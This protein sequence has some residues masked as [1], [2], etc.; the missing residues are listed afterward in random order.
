M[1]SNAIILLDAAEKELRSVDVPTL[2]LA[3][4]LTSAA[5][6]QARYYIENGNIP[7][8][9]DVVD[10]MGGVEKY[11]KA[12]VQQQQAKLV[13][14]NTVALGRF[15]VIWELGRWLRNNSPGR[16]GD[17]KSSNK[18]LLDLNSLGIEKMQSSRW[19][20]VADIEL[21]DIREW[22]REFIE[23][24]ELTFVKLVQLIGQLF[25]PER[26]DT[27]PLPDGMYRCIVADPPWPIHKL[28]RE[29]SE[30]YAD[31]GAYLDYPTMTVDDIAA[32]RV[33]DIAY[34]DGCHL[35]LWVTQKYLPAG[36]AILDAW[37][38]KYEC[39]L[40]WVK[41]SGFT[42]YSWMYNTE[43]VLFGKRGNLPLSQMGQKLAFSAPR[44]RHSEKPSIFY[45]IVKQAS[46]G[47]RLEMF[48]R[49]E[50]DGFD[51]WGNEVIANEVVAAI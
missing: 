23:T 41:P 28:E 16:G 8:A 20:R 19:Q 46:P 38:F 42:P 30:A 34:E 6:A 3:R 36:L 35:Y 50:R 45:D 32:L 17:R 26:T 10:K 13:T 14:Q 33:Q 2:E 49:S 48:A 7:A 51:V 44:G 5:L 47:P 40:T 25:G 9:R 29:L 27:P 1:D 21:E 4:A 22:G 37:G 11:I 15:E 39:V 43:H 31:Q 24:K 12:K 18:M